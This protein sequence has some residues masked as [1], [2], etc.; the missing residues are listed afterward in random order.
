MDEK[1]VY[2][3]FQSIW[4]PC[5]EVT[6]PLI[7]NLKRE[8]NDDSVFDNFAL[9]AE[10]FRKTSNKLKDDMRKARKIPPKPKITG[11]NI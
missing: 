8:R 6:Q 3:F 5:Y 2:D 1:I 4:L 9:Y 7:E 10:D 11:E